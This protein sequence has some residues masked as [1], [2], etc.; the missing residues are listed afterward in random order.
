MGVF[1][2]N[3]PFIKTSGT[4][5]EARLL[6]H[7][8]TVAAAHAQQLYG[9]RFYFLFFFEPITIKMF[10]VGDFIFTGR[11]SIAERRQGLA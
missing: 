1:Y 11:Y 8:F 5:L 7:A 2:I 9:V 3:K 4:Q 6:L 10:S